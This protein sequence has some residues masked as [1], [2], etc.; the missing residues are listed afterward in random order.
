MATVEVAREDVVRRQI[1]SVGRDANVDDALYAPDA[2]RY[3]PVTAQGMKGRD[4]IRKWH[5]M[6]VKAFTDADSRVVS[7]ISKGDFAAA[8]WAATGIHSGAFEMPM[9]TVGPTNR[10]VTLR[11]ATF[12]R[13]NR[14]GLIVEQYDYWDNANFAQQLGVKP[15]ETMSRTR[16]VSFQWQGASVKFQ[17]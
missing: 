8:E 5:E 13:F 1:E 10:R 2:V 9:G 15:L 12:Y 7:I 14:E 3:D 17:A 6:I 16:S 4:A 11:G